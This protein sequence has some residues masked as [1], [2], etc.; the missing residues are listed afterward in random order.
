MRQGYDF[1]YRY[2]GA[3]WDIGPRA[4]LVELVE[5]GRIK[6]CRAVDLGCGTASNVIFLAQHGF[7]VTRVDFSS[8]AIE[9][10][11]KRAAEKQVEVAFFQDD[12][13]NLSRDYGKFDLIVD[14]G[15]FDD[16]TLSNRSKYIQNLLTLTQPG[17]KMVLFVFEWPLRWWEKWKNYHFALEPGEVETIFSPY[18]SVERIA[19]TETATTKKVS[20]GNSTYLF[21]KMK[22]Q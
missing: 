2:I 19:G 21:Q 8:A 7:D 13:T 6:S 1:L 9:L 15:T 16:L 11:K 5:S 12:L 18:F 4:E 17:T 22:C 14:Y 3:P 10:G 20:S